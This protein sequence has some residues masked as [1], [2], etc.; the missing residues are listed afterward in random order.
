MA[1]DPKQAISK[2]VCLILAIWLC[3][4]AMLPLFGLNFIASKLVL[5]GFTPNED[6][7]YLFVTRSACMGTCVFYLLNFLRRKRPL[8]SLS[9]LLTLIVMHCVFGFAYLLVFEIG[10]MTLF[11]FLSLIAGLGFFFHSENERER[12]VVFKDSW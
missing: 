4:S 1:G 2:V 12:S 8:S 11:V 3:A 5:V 6:T 7:L 9:P 10:N